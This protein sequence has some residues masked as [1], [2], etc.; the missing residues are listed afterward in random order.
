VKDDEDWACCKADFQHLRHLCPSSVRN[1]L[2]TAKTSS[3]VFTLDLGPVMKRENSP[4]LRG[5]FLWV[6]PMPARIRLAS[7]LIHQG[8]CTD[9]HSGFWLRLTCHQGGAR[10]CLCSGECLKMLENSCAS[11]PVVNRKSG[12]EL[13]VALHYFSY[14]WAW[15]VHQLCGEQALLLQ[16]SFLCQAQSAC[17][18]THSHQTSRAVSYKTRPGAHHAN[19]RGHFRRSIFHLWTNSNSHL[20]ATTAK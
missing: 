6:F 5:I 18:L 14:A 13:L 1:L 15:Q 12:K 4:L 19:V 3:N 7:T 16:D 20:A 2:A 9:L 10:G 17:S 11:S 8:W